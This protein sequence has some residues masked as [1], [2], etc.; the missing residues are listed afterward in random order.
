MEQ[1]R[2]DQIMQTAQKMMREGSYHGTSMRDIASAVNMEAASLY[3][4][5]S[6]KEEILRAT[7]FGLAEKFNQGIQEVNDIYFNAEEKLR[8]AVKNHVLILTE[9][10]DASFVF[11]HEWRNLAEPSRGEFVKLRDKYENE[12]RQILQN[13]EDEGLFNEV[14]NK[15]AVLTILSSL[16]WVVEWY[17]SGGEMTPTQIADKLTEFILTGLK[18]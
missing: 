2:R 1:S 11:I 16:N 17:K 9:N 18:K 4:H 7:C 13:G 8:M 5:I 14:N 12:F 15:F 6:G 3:N 10:L